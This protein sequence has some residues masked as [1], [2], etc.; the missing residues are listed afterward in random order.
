MASALL[1][2][3]FENESRDGLGRGLGVGALRTKAKT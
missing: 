1:I 3:R 2:V